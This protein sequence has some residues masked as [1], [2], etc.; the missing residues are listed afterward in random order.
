VKIPNISFKDLLLIILIIFV[1]WNQYNQ[2]TPATGLLHSTE[3]HQIASGV[4]QGKTNVVTSIDTEKLT[5]AISMA[6]ANQMIKSR[7]NIISEVKGSWSNR[8][9]EQSTNVKKYKTKKKTIEWVDE[10]TGQKMPIGVAI[11]S[12]KKDAVGRDPWIAK[13]YNLKFKTEVVRS[14]DKNGGVHNTV[15]LSAHP[16][17][18]KGY[19]GVD[20]PL[21]INLDETV[22]TEVQNHKYDWS[23]WNPT[24]SMG[25]DAR[26]GIGALDYGFLLKFNFINYGYATQLPVWQ[27]VS[28]V[29]MVNG[30]NTDAGLE[31]VSYNL[32]EVLPI[33]KD[34]HIGAGIEINKKAFLSFTTVF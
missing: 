2:S 19:T 7:A 29:L 20:F 33:I 21:D 4:A 30:N 22:F 23:L 12:P 10:A 25:L 26:V 14:I 11:Y 17:N 1:G 13:A 27:F 31:F 6:V 24:L 9:N 15:A 18:L 16:A 8:K 28:P 34:L 5:T 32:G 3:A